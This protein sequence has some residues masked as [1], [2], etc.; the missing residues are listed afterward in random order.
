MSCVYD[1]DVTQKDRFPKNNNRI[2][3]NRTYSFSS[4]W[5]SDLILY[6]TVKLE[7]LN[8]RRISHSDISKH[9]GNK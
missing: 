4:A 8:H 1:A 6:V 2:H 5:H 7:T 3:S 9:E